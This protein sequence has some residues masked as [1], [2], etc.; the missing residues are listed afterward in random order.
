MTDEIKRQN[1]AE[2]VT[3]ADINLAILV[4]LKL[5]DDH[6]EEME[7][8]KELAADILRARERFA[9]LHG[10]KENAPVCNLFAEFFAG[11]N[12]GMGLADDLAEAG[13]RN[14]EDNGEDDKI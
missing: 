14:G 13:R 6:L 7:K 9:K 10:Y 2:E 4:A 5:W 11:L 8:D 3:D 1:A 12:K